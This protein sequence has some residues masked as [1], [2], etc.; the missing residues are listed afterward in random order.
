[1]F[2]DLQKDSENYIRQGDLLILDD[3]RIKTHPRVIAFPE[4]S[5]ISYILLLQQESNVIN[6][7]LNKNNT[8]LKLKVLSL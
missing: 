1:M 8:H 4:S 3:Q 2:I 5:H 6:L 7:V